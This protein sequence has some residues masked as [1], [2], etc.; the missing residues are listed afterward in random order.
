LS[1]FLSQRLEIDDV[2]HSNRVY[3]FLQ[4]ITRLVAPGGV[5]LRSKRLFWG[6]NNLNSAMFT[7]T[8]FNSLWSISKLGAW[9]G[10]HSG[11]RSLS[12]CLNDPHLVIKFVEMPLWYKDIYISMFQWMYCRSLLNLCVIDCHWGNPGLSTQILKPH[13]NSEAD[14]YYT[15]WWCAVR[16]V[17]C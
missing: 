6:A 3:Y 4:Q 8:Q 12:R 17:H 15:I 7:I 1:S 10:E 11:S 14:H 13:C 9:G 2:I 5:E 16:H